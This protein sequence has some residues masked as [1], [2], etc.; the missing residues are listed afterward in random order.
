[1]NTYELDKAGE[2]LNQHV[3]FATHTRCVCGVNVKYEYVDE[4][5]IPAE[6]KPHVPLHYPG[7]DVLKPPRDGLAL[8]MV[9]TT[10]R[11]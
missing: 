4:A 7:P 9:T 5:T 10:G 3:A 6:A 8:F 2:W 11:A 1:M